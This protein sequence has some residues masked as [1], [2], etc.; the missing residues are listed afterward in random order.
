MGGALLPLDAVASSFGHRCAR[1]GGANAPPHPRRRGSDPASI[2]LATRPLETAGRP[3]E[4]CDRERHRRAEAAAHLPIVALNYRGFTHRA[5]ATKLW[6][7]GAKNARAEVSRFE[8]LKLQLPPRTT[9]PVMVPLDT[10]A[11]SSH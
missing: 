2:V 11:Q 5:P 6:S 9:R 1:Y 8:E 10:K 7:V 3:I 4:M